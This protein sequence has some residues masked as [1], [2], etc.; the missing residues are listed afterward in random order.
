M[1][2]GTA[3]LVSTIVVLAYHC[4]YNNPGIARKVVLWVLGVA[5]IVFIAFVIWIES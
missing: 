4:A 3:L 2:L 1:S 5:L